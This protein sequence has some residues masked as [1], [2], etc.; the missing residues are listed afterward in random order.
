MTLETEVNGEGK[1]KK[2]HI[3]QQRLPEGAREL[4]PSDLLKESVR[5]KFEELLS[6]NQNLIDETGSSLELL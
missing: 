6:M 5:L 1:N 4:I 3:I 2:Y